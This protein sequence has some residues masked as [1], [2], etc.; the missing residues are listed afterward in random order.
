M[1]GKELKHH[2]I[3]GMHWGVRKPEP[4]V[5]RVT[6][7]PPNNSHQAF[8]KRE[9]ARQKRIAETTKRVSNTPYKS[10]NEKEKQHQYKNIV[11][12]VGVGVAMLA[13]GSLV[14]PTFNLVGN[15]IAKS[16][17][18]KAASLK[19]AKTIFDVVKQQGFNTSTPIGVTALSKGT[20]AADIAKKIFSSA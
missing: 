9:E 1:R 6:K 13:I 14:R 15:A 3:L 7:A 12:Y 5:D 4:T 11:E 20:A 17:Q 10:I 2:G 16:A 19:T 18:D 8:L